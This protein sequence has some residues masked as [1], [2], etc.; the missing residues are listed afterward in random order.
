ML[1]WTT[2]APGAR[3]GALVHLDDAARAVAYDRTSHVGRLA[4]GLDEGPKLGWTMVSMKNDW[5]VVFAPAR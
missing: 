2:S 3:L 5:Q 1:E 4:R